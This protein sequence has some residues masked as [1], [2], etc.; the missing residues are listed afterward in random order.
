[1]YICI[2]LFR[3]ITGLTVS[4]SGHC[5]ISGYWH[6]ILFLRGSHT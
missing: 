3:E 5:R 4:L 2:V 1:M 6:D